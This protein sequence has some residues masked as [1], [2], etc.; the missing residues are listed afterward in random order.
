MST[1]ILIW[2]LSN[3]NIVGLKW[4]SVGI[5]THMLAYVCIFMFVKFLAEKWYKV[6]YKDNF[7]KDYTSTFIMLFSLLL[8]CYSSLPNYN[9]SAFLISSYTSTFI[10]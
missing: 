4:V 3:S 8:N 1:E 9:H 5:S 10:S 7:F 6:E 2:C